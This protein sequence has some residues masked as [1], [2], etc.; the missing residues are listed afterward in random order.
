LT[1]SPRR[2]EKQKVFQ[3]IHLQ[4]KA[5]LKHGRVKEHENK[6]EQSENIDSPLI[7][8]WEKEIKGFKRKKKNKRKS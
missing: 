3:Q 8:Y 7:N 4:E 2:N 5:E 6:I 1:N